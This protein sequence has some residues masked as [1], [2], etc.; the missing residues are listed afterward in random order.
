MEQSGTGRVE[1]VCADCNSQSISPPAQEQTGD[2]HTTCYGVFFTSDTNSKFTHI[3]G[4]QNHGW[5]IQ[6]QSK[7]LAGEYTYNTVNLPCRSCKISV[8]SSGS[9]FCPLPELHFPHTKEGDTTQTV[10]KS[11]V[12]E[13][14]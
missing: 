4:C 14:T 8:L 12:K 2:T 13:K 6:L 1:R 10:N 11:T 5:L 3:I 9:R 7:I